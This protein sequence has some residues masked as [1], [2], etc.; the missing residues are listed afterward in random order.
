VDVVFLEPNLS[1]KNRVS[2]HV[3]YFLLRFVLLSPSKF[4]CDNL[5][6]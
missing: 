2:T 4:S 6:F 1:K 5:P 3:L